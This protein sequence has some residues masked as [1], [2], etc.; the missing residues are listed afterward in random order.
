MRK[1]MI[2]GILAALMCFL[3][4]AQAASAYVYAAGQLGPGSF[5]EEKGDTLSANSVSLEEPGNADI[6]KEQEA[7]LKVMTRMGRPFIRMYATRSPASSGK[8]YMGRS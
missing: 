8:N 3:P 2:A 4:A 1:R 5:L 6:R 7:P